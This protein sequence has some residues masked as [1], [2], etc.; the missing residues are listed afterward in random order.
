MIDYFLIGL[1]YLWMMV[2]VAAV[3][4]VALLPWLLGGVGI[5]VGLA[6]VREWHKREKLP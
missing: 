1:K 5:G 6:L 2:Y 4:A 3:V